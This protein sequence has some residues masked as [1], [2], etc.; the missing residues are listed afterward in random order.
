MLGFASSPQPTRLKTSASSLY[1][2]KSLTIEDLPVYL[3]VQAKLL[4]VEYRVYYSIMLFNVFAGLSIGLSVAMW[5]K[6]LRNSI[7]AKLLRKLI[8]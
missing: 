8:E 1:E 4:R 7:V 5:K 3:D 6:S 2:G